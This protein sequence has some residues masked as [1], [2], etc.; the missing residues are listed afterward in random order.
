MFI[1]RS[2]AVLWRSSSPG[3][4]L[5]TGVSRYADFHQKTER[6]VGE[7]LLYVEPFRLSLGFR[8]LDENPLLGNSRGGN[9]V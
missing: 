1:D 9:S 2:H 6:G 4:L 5:R 3:Q 8:G 7:H